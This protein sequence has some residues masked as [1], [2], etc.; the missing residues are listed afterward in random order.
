MH[1]RVWMSSLRQERRF[2][3]Y[4]CMNVIFVPNAQISEPARL[5]QGKIDR[6]L[7]KQT[8][9]TT[10]YGVTLIGAKDQ[11]QNRLHESYGEAGS[12]E[13]TEEQVLCVC[14]C[15]FS[16]VPPSMHTR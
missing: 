13:L 6:K 14:V 11:I 5:V 2:Q 1:T 12:K 10:V 15:V 3:A 16:F 7:V 4:T 8:V 9:M